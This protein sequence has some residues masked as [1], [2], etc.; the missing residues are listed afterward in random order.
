MNSDSGTTFCTIA[1]AYKRHKRR[2]IRIKFIHM[3]IQIYMW[4]QI[5]AQ[6]SASE[7]EVRILRAQLEG[8]GG[9][10]HSAEET[11]ALQVKAHAYIYTYIH[12]YIN[13]WALCRRNSRVAGKG[14]YMHTYIHTRTHTGAR[15]RIGRSQ[16]SSHKAACR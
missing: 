7:I 10:G 1:A 12:T 13:T 8:D 11:R 5:R 6:H 4:T 16:T 15:R 9:K 2:S 3:H 14:T